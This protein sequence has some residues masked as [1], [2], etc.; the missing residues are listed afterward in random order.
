MNPLIYGVTSLYHVKLISNIVPGLGQS[1]THCETEVKISPMHKTPAASQ[2]SFKLSG[3]ICLAASVN[4]ERVNTLYC[5]DRIGRDLPSKRKPSIWY[6][7]MS[8]LTQLFK[9]ALTEELSVLTSTS[10]TSDDINGV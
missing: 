4:A 9:V 8:P 2:N 10:A 6:S 7:L 1:K 3:A 5:V